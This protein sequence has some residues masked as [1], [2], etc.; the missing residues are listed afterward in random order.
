[1]TLNGRKIVLLN[2]TSQMTHHFYLHNQLIN[3][4]EVWWVIC[5]QIAN[6][7]QKKAKQ[8]LQEHEL[9]NKAQCSAPR[10]K[11]QAHSFWIMYILVTTRWGR[12]AQGDRH[13]QPSNM[14]ANTLLEL[15]KH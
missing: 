12:G 13:E 14:Q 8:L 5:S 3:D 10:T 2:P 1:M 9:G 11:P 7:F 4:S 6:V 15:A